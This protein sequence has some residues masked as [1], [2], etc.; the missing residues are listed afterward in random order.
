MTALLQN[1]ARKHKIE[2]D[3]LSFKFSYTDQ[4]DP[5]DYESDIFIGSKAEENGL[6]IDKPAD[7]ALVSGLYFEGCRWDYENKCLS[8]SIPK[9]LYSKV[10][11]IWLKPTEQRSKSP[12][13]FK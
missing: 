4:E 5:T 13:T 10:P 2:I 7:G 6:Q 11:I 9:Q 3:A 12:T 1:Y 8:E